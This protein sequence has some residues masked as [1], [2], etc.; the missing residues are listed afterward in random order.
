MKPREI[1]RMDRHASGTLS[2]AYSILVAHQFVEVWGKVR[3]SAGRTIVSAVRQGPHLEKKREV[4]MPEVQIA[5]FG[6]RQV[7]LRLKAEIH[8][9]RG[10]HFDGFS[11][12]KRRSV[13][14]L[15]DGF[16]G[17]AGE[18]GIDLAVHDA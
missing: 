18:I 8:H 3:S 9:D 12:E 14:P 6:H 15:A 5:G 13:T 11:V 10:V 2:R 7:R 17:G 4:A 16:D 1:P